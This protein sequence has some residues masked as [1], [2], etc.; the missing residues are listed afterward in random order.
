MDVLRDLK[1]LTLPISTKIAVVTLLLLS[2]GVNIGFLVWGLTRQEAGLL[3]S[4]I[5][6][7]AA[8]LPVVL[9]VIVLGRA[10]SGVSA[11]KRRTE[12]MFLRIL[13]P[14]LAG[15]V[16]DSIEFYAAGSSARA[17]IAPRSGSVYVNLKR[18]ECYADILIVTPWRNAPETVPIWKAI[19]IHLEI[20]VGRVNFGL[21][22]PDAVSGLTAEAAAVAFQHTTEGA[23]RTGPAEPGKTAATG[24]SFIDLPLARTIDGVDYTVLVANKFVPGDFLWDSASQLYFAQDLMFMLRAFLSECPDRFVSIS[25]TSVPRPGDVARALAN[26]KP[27]TAKA[28]RTESD[29]RA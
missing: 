13:P 22:L 9:V 28:D 7:L 15:V 20:N 11:L 5:E 1:T 25:G 23:G 26:V 24:Y 16:D 10:D 8:L 27:R 21:M 19:L 4:S 17:P 3:S 14:I 12:I 6:T 2:V 29:G 18:G